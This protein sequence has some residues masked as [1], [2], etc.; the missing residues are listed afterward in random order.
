MVFQDKFAGALIGQA[1]GDAFC[2]PLSTGI[3]NEKLDFIRYEKNGKEYDAGD[4]TEHT[5][6]TIELASNLISNCQLKQEVFTNKIKETISS[7]LIPGCVVPIGLLR[8]GRPA[9][10]AGDIENIFSNWIEPIN[11]DFVARCKALCAAT[12]VAV[13]SPEADDIIEAAIQF[14]EY[15]SSK[16]T[17][18]SLKELVKVLRI[19]HEIEG[20]KRFSNESTAD[21]SFA[22]AVG[23]FRIFSD[24][25]ENLLLET[26]NLRSYQLP[27]GII[28][29][30]LVG[31]FCGF[32]RIPNRW[33]EKV[34]DS[35]KLKDLAEKL[36]TCFEKQVKDS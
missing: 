15:K 23:M 2:S 3:I 9:L 25:F 32:D 35:V 8:S 12:S 24:D 29:G 18:D 21:T 4:W 20:L 36:F 10:A 33:S 26:V 14:S 34:K 6:I 22:L 13:F 7:S 17:H 1:I 11:N 31:A 27:V 30:S 16:S 19:S 5:E 28:A